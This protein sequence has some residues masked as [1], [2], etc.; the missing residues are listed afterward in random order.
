MLTF[1]DTFIFF[2][3]KVD[4]SDFMTGVIL[5]QALKEDGKWYLVIFLSKSLFLVVCN[6]KIHNKE[7]FAIICILEKWYHF[8]EEALA[9]VK[10]WTDYKNLKY[11]ITTK[12][13]D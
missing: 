1:P 8:L 3:I 10:I 6:Y 11:F 12:K 2:C 4:S 13:L 5:S 9:L 7:I